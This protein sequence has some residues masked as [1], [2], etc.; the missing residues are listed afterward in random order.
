MTYRSK[1]R[2]SDSSKGWNDIVDSVQF[3]NAADTAMLHFMSLLGSPTNTEVASANEWRRQ[4]A[5]AFLDVLVNL[6]TEIKQTT[7]YDR[8]N[9]NQQ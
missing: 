1:F 6:N 4:G 2:K 3:S 9:L 5:L 8:S 7:K